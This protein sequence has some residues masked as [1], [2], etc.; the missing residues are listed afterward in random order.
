M[1][2]PG[3]VPK[4]PV[5]PLGGVAVVTQPNISISASIREAVARELGALPDDAKGAIV[6]VATTKGMNLAVAYKLDSGWNVGAFI[7]KS[8]W[9][10]PIE[11]GV[12]VQR[13]F[14]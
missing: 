11:G 13:V 6:G 12:L 7:G 1:T 3:Q 2:T 8:G 14:R 9:D 10:Q 5:A 4:S